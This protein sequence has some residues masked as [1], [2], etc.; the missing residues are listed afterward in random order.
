MI[1]LEAGTIL[2]NGQSVDHMADKVLSDT[3]GVV[4]QFPFYFDGWTLGDFIDP[5]HQYSVEKVHW[6]FTELGVLDFILNNVKVKKDPNESQLTTLRTALGMPFKS[7]SNI[8]LSEKDGGSGD[9]HLINE[10]LLRHLSFARLIMGSEK[11]QVVLIDEPPNMDNY[12]GST[13]AS[14]QSLIAKYLSHCVT[15]IVTHDFNYVKICKKLWVMSKGKVVEEL[16]P[17]NI[18]SHVEFSQ[19]I[20]NLCSSI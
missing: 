4:S 12:M 18:E 5:S 10:T 14:L 2:I 16:S 3:I 15:I 6:A 7:G 11:Y 9:V 1:P 19:I 8:L 17:E 20:E 13:P